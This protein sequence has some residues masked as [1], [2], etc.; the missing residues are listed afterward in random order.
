MGKL[1][2]GQKV[3]LRD[4]L[5]HREKYG[6]EFFVNGMISDRIVQIKGVSP[7][8]NDKIWI[9]GCSFAYTYYMIDLDK[10][11]DIPTKDD[12]VALEIKNV[13][14][15]LLE[16]GFTREEALKIMLNAGNV[17]NK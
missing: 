4:D 8:G 16:V 7:E 3:W 6:S 13:F 11:R 1:K 17:G 2:V 15:S 5:K 10:T 14:D 9:D 12:S